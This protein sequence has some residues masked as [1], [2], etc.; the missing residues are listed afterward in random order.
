M[1]SSLTN[2][3][4]RMIYISSLF[5]ELRLPENIHFKLGLLKAIKEYQ[6]AIRKSKK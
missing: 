4:K 2:D 5:A 3:R 1:F 6:K